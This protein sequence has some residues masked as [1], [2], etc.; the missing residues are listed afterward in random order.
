MRKYILTCF[1]IIKDIK[2]VKVKFYMLKNKII[3]ML[4]SLEN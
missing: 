1:E 3:T 2:V 4:N